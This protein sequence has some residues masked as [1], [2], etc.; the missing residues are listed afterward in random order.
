[1]NTSQSERSSTL[2]PGVQISDQPGGDPAAN[3]MAGSVIGAGARAIDRLLWSLWLS[4][5]LVIWPSSDWIGLL[6]L[7]QAFF[8]AA[9][10][11]QTSSVKTQPAASSSRALIGMEQGEDCV[12]G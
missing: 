11:L 12:Q 5:L 3:L 8:V 4:L 9:K 2:A 10:L 7:S 1:M 6:I